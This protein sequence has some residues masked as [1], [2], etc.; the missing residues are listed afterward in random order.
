LVDQVGIEIPERLIQ[1]MDED[2]QPIEA[3]SADM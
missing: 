1:E 2:G 3:P